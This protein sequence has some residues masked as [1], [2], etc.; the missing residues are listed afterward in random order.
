MANESPA[1]DKACEDPQTP[2][3]KAEHMHPLEL[4]PYFRRWAP[5]TA[6]DLI[7]TVIFSLLI[8]SGFIIVALP[9]IHLQSWGEFGEMLVTNVAVSIC[10]GFTWHFF[11]HLLGP[12]LRQVHG[13]PFWLVILVYTILGFAI[14]E[15]GFLVLS[16]IPGYVEV[17][18]WMFTPKAWVSTL[19]ISFVISL[20]LGYAFRASI[21]GLTLAAEL[22][23]E[24]ERL[25]AAE[26]AAVQANLRAL[27]A[28]IE[29][30][31]LFNTLANVTGLI[32]KQPDTAK[33][34]L[35]EFIAYLRATLAATREEHT[36]LGQEFAL[37]KSFL[38]VLQVR[39]GERLQ[40]SFDLP[41]ELSGMPMPQMLLQPLVENAIK[42]GLEPYID[43]GE[44]TLSA[45][46]E[47]PLVA[48]TVADTGVG[49]GN[50]TS[51][52]LG[53]Q[54]VR[55]RLAKLFGEAGRL[56]IEDNAPRGVRSGTRVTITLPLQAAKNQEEK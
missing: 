43:G 45:R 30:H 5:S 32:H 14:T 12:L 52:G 20:I 29:P 55:E 54:N 27:Q 6:R 21:A 44:I 28:Q 7:Y 2:A 15:I 1:R 42:H 50:T 11:M 13:K 47:G 35:E 48:I 16:L 31:F 46:H 41:D 19:C 8:A 37:M 26:R 17:R 18:Q 33:H 53:L 36:T 56:V 34:M 24:R 39:M 10:I 51:G 25:E 23:R 4:I 22:A 3:E 49:F 9:S 40:V 38:A